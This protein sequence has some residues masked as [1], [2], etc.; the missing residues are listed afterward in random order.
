MQNKYVWNHCFSEQVCN[1]K[2]IYIWKHVVEFK[3]REKVI[4]VVVFVCGGWSTQIEQAQKGLEALS[5]SQKKIDQLHENFI[6]IDRYVCFGGGGVRKSF[7]VL[8]FYAFC[9]VVK[10]W[11]CWGISGTVGNAK[12]WLKTMTRSSYLAMLGII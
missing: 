10:M 2:T 11:V 6:A 7:D 1:L 9:F 8:F 4:W 5:L 12:L 3:K